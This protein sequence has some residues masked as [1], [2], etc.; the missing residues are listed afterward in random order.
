[1]PTQRKPLQEPEQIQRRWV[2]SNLHFIALAEPHFSEARLRRF[3]YYPSD[4]LGKLRCGQHRDSFG[5]I[6]KICRAVEFPEAKT[7]FLRCEFGEGESVPEVYVEP[8]GGAEWADVINEARALL[9]R[10]P[11]EKDRCSKNARTLLDWAARVPTGETA[12]MPTRS[13][14]DWSNNDAECAVAQSREFD[15][16]LYIEEDDES[17]DWTIG[18]APEPFDHLVSPVINEPLPIPADKEFGK[19]ELDTFAARVHEIVLSRTNLS[20]S[21]SLVLLRTGLRAD[22][23]RCLGCGMSWDYHLLG[24][25]NAVRLIGMH[26]RWDLRKCSPVWRIWVNPYGELNW[27]EVR[28][29]ISQRLSEEPSERRYCLSPNAALLFDWLQSLDRAGF[30]YGLTPVVEDAWKNE[31]GIECSWEKENR[32]L[33]IELLCEEIS[34]KTGRMA[35]PRPWHHWGET[36]TR[37]QF[38]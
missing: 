17:Y 5:K 11:V 15:P 13:P 25:L 32:S 8:K 9:G 14:K 1:V 28:A 7:F 31:I 33:L 35:R 2:E 19:A 37:I 18:V 10:A 22:L 4:F 30:E 12:E 20:G 34:E 29:L 16:R 26:L 36:K 24:F 38:E 3:F 27:S 6:L 21:S 23:V